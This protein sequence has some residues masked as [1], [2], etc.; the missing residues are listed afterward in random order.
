MSTELDSIDLVDIHPE[1][2]LAVAVNLQSGEFAFTNGDSLRQNWESSKAQRLSPWSQLPLRP[3]QIQVFCPD[4]KRLIVKFHSELRLLGDEVKPAAKPTNQGGKM[5]VKKL[6]PKKGAVPPKA[7]ASAAAPKPAAAPAAAAK[8]VKPVAASKAAAAKPPK[9]AKPEGNYAWL[10]HRLKAQVVE[11]LTNPT[12]RSA[13]REGL[14][15]LD[16]LN[17]VKTFIAG[18][19]VGA[20][21]FD[22]FLND[23]F[24]AHKITRKDA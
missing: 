24:F 10:M 9:P 19:D 20:D 15:K 11:H 21:A 23:V 18:T 4:G 2:L 13:I 12:N 7:A 17:S 16:D 22:T 3:G 6:P 5:P 14:K 8:P 1:A